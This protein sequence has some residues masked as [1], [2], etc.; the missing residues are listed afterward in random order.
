M[1]IAT[2][3]YKDTKQ[4]FSLVIKGRF[5]LGSRVQKERGGLKEDREFREFK[6]FRERT[7]LVETLLP[8]FSK[9]PKFPNFPKLPKFPNHN[10]D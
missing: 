6:E 7:E 3:N 9:L 4:F 8:K 2:I 10:H 1:H 5:F